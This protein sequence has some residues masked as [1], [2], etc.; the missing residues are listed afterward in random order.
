ALPA[1]LWPQ[2][3][4]GLGGLEPPTSP[5]SVVRSNHLSYR[6]KTVLATPAGPNAFPFGQAICVST[7]LGRP[8]SHKEVIQP[9]V[10]LRLPCYDFTAD[11]S[12]TEVSALPK[13]KLPTSGA[14]DSHG[15]TGGVYNA[16]ERI[17]RDILIH[18]YERF[19]LH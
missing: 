18:D 16:R 19:R 10:H 13:G 8:R 11:M 17:H 9:Q 5:L 1:E 12:H 3:L 4:V 7:G 14:I 6:P 15:V 2:I